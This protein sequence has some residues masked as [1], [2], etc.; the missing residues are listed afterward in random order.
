MG[1][2]AFCFTRQVKQYSSDEVQK[3]CL[4]MLKCAAF[5]RNS[6]LQEKQTYPGWGSPWECCSC[7]PA[8]GIG[9]RHC[10]SRL[11]ERCQ[12]SADA[13]GGT[14]RG[15]HAFHWP[16][17]E[18]TDISHSQSFHPKGPAPGAYQDVSFILPFLWKKQ[19]GI[20]HFSWQCP[21]CNLTRTWE[22]FPL[23]WNQEM[24]PASREKLGKVWLMQQFLKR[25]HQTSLFLRDGSIAYKPHLKDFSDWT[26][27]TV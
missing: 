27:Y 6:F 26:E 12:D 1:L 25:Y 15:E 8:L 3:W 5:P 11:P 19:K 13:P 2:W 22:L 18:D 16:G 21:F 14:R 10:S 24:T 9:C 17:W 4:E 7:P 20:Y 23:S